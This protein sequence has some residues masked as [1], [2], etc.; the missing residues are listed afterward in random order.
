L[1]DLSNELKEFIA[2]HCHSVIRLEVLLLLSEDRNK[3][4]SADA[5]DRKLNLTPTSAKAHLDE[6]V[7]QGLLRLVDGPTE[8]QYRYRPS[9]D[10]LDKTV[11]QLSNAYATQRVAV[12][13]MIFANPVDKV[14]L[15]TETFRMINGESESDCVD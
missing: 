9:S 5:V 11:G 7:S 4:W 10:K 15:F 13:T 2:G 8:E 14:R 6:L 3:V 12:L 1:G